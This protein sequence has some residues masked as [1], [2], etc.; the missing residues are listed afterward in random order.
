M[1]HDAER[2]GNIARK[3]SHDRKQRVDPASRTADDDEI[4]TS[5]GSF[6]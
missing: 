6:Q 4:V 3:L 1:D 5:Q 2:R